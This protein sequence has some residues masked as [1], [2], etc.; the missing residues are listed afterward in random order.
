MDEMSPREEVQIIHS[1]RSTRMRRWESQAYMSSSAD[2]EGR[3]KGKCVGSYVPRYESRKF[4]S[5]AFFFLGWGR[6]EVH[7]I[8]VC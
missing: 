3:G 8:V 6:G 5:E 2:Q 7:G 1:V 4:L